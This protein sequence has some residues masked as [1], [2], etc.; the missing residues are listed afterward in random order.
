MTPVR[1]RTILWSLAIGALTPALAFAQEKKAAEKT[2]KVIK[3][4]DDLDKAL[5]KDA[6]IEPETKKALQ[7]LNKALKDERKEQEE[8]GFWK[9]LKTLKEWKDT[10]GIGGD[11]RIRH[12]TLTHRHPVTGRTVHRPTRNRSRIRLRIGFKF[13]PHEDLEIGARLRTGNP[14]DPA[15]PHQSLDDQFD[16]FEFN[17]DRAYVKYEP[18]WAGGLYMIGGKFKH[19]L[20][21]SPA[22]DGFIWDGD[23]HPTGA[24]VGYVRKKIGPIAKLAI[25]T[26][27]YVYHEENV[28]DEAYVFVAQIALEFKLGPVSPTLAVAYYRWSDMAPDSDQDVVNR[29]AGNSLKTDADGSLAYAHRFG[30]LHTIVALKLDVGIPIVASA[31]HAW[32]TAMNGGQ[33]SKEH[34]WAFA[35][36]VGKAKKQFDWRIYYAWLVVE[37]DAVVSFV[38]QD[39][40]QARVNFRG[41]IVGI[42]FM[43]LDAMRL[44]LR[45]M[46]D[47]N[48]FDP[49]ATTA[50]DDYQYRWRAD[51]D[52][53]F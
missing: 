46:A 26:G 11:F 2:D 1:S 4:L 37:Q 42:Q 34:A 32:N 25:H 7:D 10:F 40:F 50:R 31:E 19:Q 9:A 14:N 52:I 43:L 3:A 12:E 13:K 5:D 8:S 51:I 49:G 41:H 53:K 36:S 17:L 22:Y 23:V 38:A 35:L 30:V 44:H 27:Q 29:N 33:R 21:K 18:A 28:K 6:K 39:D 15:S 24:G 16:S 45:M 20:Y 48:D 47:A